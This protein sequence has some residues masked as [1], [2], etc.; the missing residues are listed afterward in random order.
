MRNILFCIL[1]FISGFS[2]ADTAVKVNQ[3]SVNKGLSQQDVETAMQDRYGF[4]WFGTYDGLNRYDGY[5]IETFRYD[6]QIPNSIADNRITALFESSDGI[7][8]IGTEGSGLLYFDPSTDTFG[9]VEHPYL[10]AGQC[11]SIYALQETANKVLLVGS[12]QALLMI[13]DGNKPHPKVKKTVLGGD[14]RYRI[15]NLWL[16]KENELWVGTQN[17]GMLKLLISEHNK[18]TLVF[19]SR[20]MQ[21]AYGVIP[22]ENSRY[23]V[24][25]EGGIKFYR[26]AG[27]L[28]YKK[29]GADIFSD[30]VVIKIV[31]KKNGWLVL[32]KNAV[33]DWGG[34]GEPRLFIGQEQNFVK[35]NILQ[36]IFIDRSNILWITSRNKGVA[37]VDLTPEKFN[38]L[39]LPEKDL[40][41]KSMIIQHDG[42]KA[43]GIKDFGLLQE[44][45][46]ASGK[47]NRLFR[48]K[49]ISNLMEDS[50]RNVWLFSDKLDVMSASGSITPF[51]SFA[52]YTASMGNHMSCSE[53]NGGNVWIGAS[54]AI[55]KADVESK[56]VSYIRFPKNQYTSTENLSLNIYYNQFDNSLLCCTKE[57]GLYRYDIAA[58][59]LRQF[60]VKN[61]LTS[62]HVWSIAIQNDSVMW[63]GT[64]VGINKATYKNGVFRF[65]PASDDAR[66]RN[67]KVMAM[68]FDK[69]NNLWITTSQGLYA[70]NTVN[71]HILEYNFSDGLLS[72]TLSEVAFMDKQGIV[73]ISSISGLNYF[74]P[75]KLQPN[76]YE[77]N[78]VLR[79]LKVFNESIHPKY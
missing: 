79:D 64:D 61:G 68:C 4:M 2:M 32:T 63:I 3:L 47:Y 71:P 17:G 33:Y 5:R 36:T 49:T 52:G 1:L 21:F 58:N 26:S 8:W 65:L 25:G 11:G 40:F 7:I 6:P 27:G 39:T 13:W 50:R 20:S 78:I 12:T 66:V 56:T 28:N 31:K 42:R 41:V 54:H 46:P 38:E 45:A 43:I 51:S 72:N 62:N 57:E 53:D 74:D 73:W 37:Q 34:V 22:L 76:R 23:A 18:P 69:S 15:R 24:Y 70:F 55:C 35:N 48:G 9:K 67:A 77:P 60:T 10:K 30:D 29:D 75:E 59:R 19:H 14:N 16:E 44:T